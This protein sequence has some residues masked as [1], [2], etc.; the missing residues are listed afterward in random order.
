M[1]KQQVAKSESEFAAGF[2]ERT[3]SF[4]FTAFLSVE[5]IWKYI[6]ARSNTFVCQFCSVLYSDFAYTTP[7]TTVLRCHPLSRVCSEPLQR[8]GTAGRMSF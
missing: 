2:E 3:S 5:S 7:Q 1:R 8:P 6:H 4:S